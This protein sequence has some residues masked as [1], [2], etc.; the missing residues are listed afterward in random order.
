M[1]LARIN[2]HHK[3]KKVN[4]LKKQSIKYH[5]VTNRYFTLM[6]ENADNLK[7]VLIPKLYCFASMRTIIAVV[8]SVVAIVQQLVC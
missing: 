8:V 5:S 1:E 3:I 2:V 4:R 6:I 7:E